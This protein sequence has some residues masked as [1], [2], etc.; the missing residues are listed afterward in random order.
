MKKYKKVYI[1]ITNRCNLSCD[2]CIKNKK[3]APCPN[4]LG[5]SSNLPI[6]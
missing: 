2:F 6:Y 4:G 1:E 3:E 5:A